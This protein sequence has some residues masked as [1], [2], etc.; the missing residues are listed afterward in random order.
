MNTKQHKWNCIFVLNSNLQAVKCYPL[1]D[2]EKHVMKIHR[3]KRRNLNKM[4]GKY[5]YEV[6]KLCSI[7]EYA[8]PGLNPENEMD[9]SESYYSQS[10]S[11]PETEFPSIEEP[12]QDSADLELVSIDWLLNPKM[13]VSA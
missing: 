9:D 12:K 4:T 6:Y 10:E 3:Q 8:E 13:I 7:F 5:A 11:S 1:D 2:E